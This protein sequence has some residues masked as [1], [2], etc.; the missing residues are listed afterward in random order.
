MPIPSD[1][2]DIALTKGELSATTTGRL[3]PGIKPLPAIVS[4]T[5]ALVLSLLVGEDAATCVVDDVN[6]GLWI[7]HEEIASVAD[8]ELG[9][10]GRGE[11]DSNGEVEGAWLRADLRVR[12]VEE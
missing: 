12:G 3:V 10:D 11:V 7:P 1:I 4:D 6:F 8:E 2:L 5:K 9:C